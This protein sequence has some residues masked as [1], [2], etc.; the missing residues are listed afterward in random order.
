VLCWLIRRW[1]AHMPS[2][3]DIHDAPP[4]TWARDKILSRCHILSCV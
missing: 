2:W 3:F 4:I 1:R